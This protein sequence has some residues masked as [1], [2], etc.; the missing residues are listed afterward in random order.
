MPKA[1]NQSP[2]NKE[3]N[4]NRV[5]LG[6]MVTETEL[7]KTG[8]GHKVYRSVDNL[9][10]ADEKK[11]GRDFK[12]FLRFSLS[13]GELA[14]CLNLQRVGDAEPSKSQRGDWSDKKSQGQPQA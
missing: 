8:D 6:A 12:E 4:N 5:S 1:D 13:G 9:L 14:N 10:D 7:I 3:E 11:L 2:E